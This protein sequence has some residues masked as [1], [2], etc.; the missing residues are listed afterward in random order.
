R[1]EPMNSRKLAISVVILGSILLTGCGKFIGNLR[2][3]LDDSEPYSQ[4]TYGGRWTEKGFLS[5]NLPEGPDRYAQVGHSE[6]NPASDAAQGDNGSW[7]SPERAEAN[8][9]D[10]YRYSGVDEMDGQG[11]TMS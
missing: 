9:R 1:G 7:I 6:R 3:D 4:P 2:R 8:A 5:E 10:R 11:V